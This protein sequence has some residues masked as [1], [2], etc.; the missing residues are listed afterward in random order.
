MPELVGWEDS[1]GQVHGSDT[2]EIEGGESLW[3]VLVLPA[4]DTVTEIGIK[5]EAVKSS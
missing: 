3:R 1:D 4:P 2:F 5:V